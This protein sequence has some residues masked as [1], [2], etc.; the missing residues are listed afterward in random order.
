MTRRW[1]LWEK[2]RGWPQGFWLGNW[3]YFLYWEKQKEKTDWVGRARCQY[4]NLPS[5]SYLQTFYGDVPQTVRHGDLQLWPVL[6]AGLRSVSTALDEPKL[7]LWKRVELEERG[8]ARTTRMSS[9]EEQEWIGDREMYSGGWK[10]G[11]HGRTH[12]SQK[13]PK[14]MGNWDRCQRRWLEGKTHTIILDNS[15]ESGNLMQC[16]KLGNQITEY[17]KTNGKE[18]WCII[19]T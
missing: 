19:G 14:S 12:R 3:Q 7:T 10:E 11:R 8:L 1:R 17:E 9:S 6:S 5:L 2:T 4:E 15:G 16:F 13:E 18:N